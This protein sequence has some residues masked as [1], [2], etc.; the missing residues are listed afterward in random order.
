[1]LVLIGHDQDGRVFHF[2]KGSNG[3][4]Y[5]ICLRCGRAASETAHDEKKS[6]LNR[7]GQH[8]KLRT[9]NKK[10]NTDICEA[11]DDSYAVQRYIWL[12]GEE[13]TDVFQ[14]R[15][16]SFDGRDGGI[17]EE[18]AVPLAIGLRNALAEFLGIDS[19]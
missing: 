8:K 14:L 15:L 4:G 19:S 5:A 9:G 2:S 18:V 12:G 3:F 10:Q 7:D 13:V 11:T 16:R 6:P 17:D 1:M